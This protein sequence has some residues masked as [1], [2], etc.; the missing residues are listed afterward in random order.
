PG[1]DAGGRRE[2]ERLAGVLGAAAWVGIPD[3]KS[4]LLDVHGPRVLH[5]AAPRFCVGEP[6]SDLSQRGHA[7]V[8]VAPNRRPERAWQQRLRRAGLLLSRPP[9]AAGAEALTAREISRLDLDGTE[10]VALTAGGVDGR[11][12]G[13]EPSAPVRTDQ[14]TV[15]VQRA[16]V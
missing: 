14:G 9:G 16:L 15:A 4:R 5:L 6:P 13:S 8:G 11:E 10:W 7:Q 3:L 2:V 1:G 12:E